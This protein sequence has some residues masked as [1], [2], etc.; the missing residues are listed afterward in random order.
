MMGDE[1]RTRLTEIRGKIGGSN[2]AP[3]HQ[4]QEDRDLNGYSS[5]NDSKNDMSDRI[6]RI[7]LQILKERLRREASNRHSYSPVLNQL[8]HSHSLPQVA[9]AHQNG[10]DTS[11]QFTGIPG[12]PS[13]VVS[14]AIHSHGPARMG[15][16]I[17][18][19]ML[20]IMRENG[21]ISNVGSGY[22]SIHG[23]RQVPTQQLDWV[24][25]SFEASVASQFQ[26][27]IQYS[28]G[29]SSRNA[30]L[31]QRVQ[32][33]QLARENEERQVEFMLRAM[34]ELSQQV[35]LLHWSSS[36]LACCFICLH[37]VI[38]AHLCSHQPSS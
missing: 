25:R 37:F 16:R 30:L 18:E 19:P 9:S 7:R 29:F 38:S 5:K 12:V 21:V 4:L 10:L 24:G 13:G 2:R 11:F 33:E 31:R 8:G 3:L 20:P 26:T 6:A 17:S 36:F 14:S 32:L 35:A 15:Q 34:N 23:L 28:S 27:P 1:F 22:G